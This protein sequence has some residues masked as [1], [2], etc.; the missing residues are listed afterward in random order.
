MTLRAA[1]QKDSMQ[2]SVAFLY[3][4]TGGGH[5]ASAQAV[6][7]ELEARYGSVV[8][9]HMLDPTKV[10][11]S[12]LIRASDRLY[13]WCIRFTPWVW[14][15]LFHTTNHRWIVWVLRKTILRSLTTSL[16]TLRADTNFDVIVSFHP[17]L[18][19]AAREVA[20]DTPGTMAMTVVTDR[21]EPHASWAHTGIDA[22]FV[23][24]KS[25]AIAITRLGVEE[26]KCHCVGLPVGRQFVEPFHDLTRKFT[27][28]TATTTATPA[29]TRTATP[30]AIRT[31][32]TATTTT[33]PRFSVLLV[34][35]G[36]GWGGLYRKARRILNNCPEVEVCVI[37]GRNERLLE[38]LH[39]LQ[40]RYPE[41]L[42]PAGFVTDMAERMR[43]A[44]LMVTKA[45]PGSIAEAL[46]IGTPLLITGHLRGQERRNPNFVLIGQAGLRARHNRQMVKHVQRC[47]NDR[48]LL[49]RFS[50]SAR[51][52]SRPWAAK[53]IAD[54]LVRSMGTSSCVDLGSDRTSAS[55]WP[56]V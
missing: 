52:L 34:G 22:T 12:P 1:L 40:V 41:R 6:K 42:V 49:D 15:I 43:S 2:K 7:R 3:A 14:A 29:A 11:R 28:P 9:V 39:R 35:G 48:P 18:S 24:N 13:I 25:S 21:F 10:N 45:G 47:A 27:I 4:D 30:A 51:L 55:G 53:E 44:D 37:A 5:R 46:A 38:K 36:E 26:A 50:W 33:E 17:L 54:E 56:S 23:P 16:R 32:I 19:H 20:N 31:A 8:S